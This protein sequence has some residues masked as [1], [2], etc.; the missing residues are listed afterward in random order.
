MSLVVKFFEIEWII[1]AQT[2]MISSMI[3]AAV[4]QGTFPCSSIYLAIVLG[5]GFLLIM[6]AAHSG[7]LAVN[8]GTERVRGDFI[9]EINLGSVSSNDLISRDSSG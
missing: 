6:N 8:L 4:A 5:C 7:T 1:A 9:N 2:I 3:C